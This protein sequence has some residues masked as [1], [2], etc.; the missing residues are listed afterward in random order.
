M[1]TT[2]FYAIIA[3]RRPNT[4]M[5]NFFQT[6]PSAQSESAADSPPL[7]RRSKTKL[8]TDR[9]LNTITMDQCESVAP[10]VPPLEHQQ[11]ALPHVVEHRNLEQEEKLA[12]IASLPSPD[13]QDQQHHLSPL[14]FRRPLGP[15]Q[16]DGGSRDP[17]CLRCA[18]CD[19]SLEEGQGDGEQS[20]NREVALRLQHH[21]SFSSPSS[22]TVDRSTSPLAPSFNS[23]VVNEVSVSL[24]SPALTKVGEPSNVNSITSTPPISSAPVVANA[25][26]QGPRSM[27]AKSAG[28]WSLNSNGAD[29]CRICHCEASQDFPLIAPCYC[30]GSLKFVH[31]QCLQM[32]IKSSQTRSC[33]VCRFNFI[34]QTK[35]KPF[36]KWEKLNMSTT[37]R[38]KI[39]C[40][41]SFHVIALTCVLWSLYV[42]I[43]RTANEVSD[44]SR[45]EWSFWTKLVVVAVGITGGLVF[46]YAQCKMY[47]LLCRRWRAYN[48][49]VFVQNGPADTDKQRPSPQAPGPSAPVAPAVAEA[50]LEMK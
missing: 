17:R 15:V 45:L 38:R 23:D 16:Q 27:S 31:Q 6:S 18:T 8:R 36:S 33:E 2:G 9:F 20:T 13:N 50:V 7:L 49:V 47:L 12:E 32:W 4:S 22:I 35:M 19:V 30:S 42:L 41:V 11:P 29:I 34:M 44:E 40:S 48:N 10:F 21:K 43:E 5:F 1:R 39:A 28:V 46:M 24:Q 26:T 37:E 3:A 25:A 14:F